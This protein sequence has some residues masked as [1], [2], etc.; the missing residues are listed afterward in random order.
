MG[1]ERST[2]LPKVTAGK[3]QN[4]N[5]NPAGL[6]QGLVLGCCTR[7]EHRRCSDEGPGRALGALCQQ[8][9]GKVGLGLRG[10]GRPGSQSASTQKGYGYCC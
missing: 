8:E 7:K 3:C 2:D 9:R 6:V 10:E 5:L 4:K 1:I